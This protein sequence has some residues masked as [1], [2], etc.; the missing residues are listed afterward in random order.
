MLDYIKTITQTMKS[1]GFDILDYAKDN[2]KTVNKAAF[3]YFKKHNPD[4]AVSD[5]LIV[6]I[7]RYVNC[8]YQERLRKETIWSDTSLIYHGDTIRCQLGELDITA[9]VIITPEEIRVRSNENYENVACGQ[10]V[11]NLLINT[12]FG[13]FLS[14]EGAE[15][16]KD[17]ILRLLLGT[18]SL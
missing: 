15:K 10:P 18:Q 17:A 1:F 11:D 16:V 7:M 8:V 5:A 9:V 12:S 14:Q 6:D 3:A 13:T 2:G 4:V